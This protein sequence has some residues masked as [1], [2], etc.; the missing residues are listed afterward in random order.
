MEYILTLGVCIILISLLVD[1]VTR[2]EAKQQNVSRTRVDILLAELKELEE[3]QERKS[4]LLLEEA[5]IKSKQEKIK[6]EQSEIELL[7]AFEEGIRVREQERLEILK[8]REEA[9]LAQ[10]A[11]EEARLDE[12][13]AKEE[14]EK[15]ARSVF[16]LVYG[17]TAVDSPSFQVVFCDRSEGLTESLEQSAIVS[18]L[19]LPQVRFDL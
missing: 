6:R 10:K 17:I 14:E 9:R 15:R 7:R 3:E 5:R 12:Q 13:K 4:K 1:W 19:G 8:A 2:G 11:E 16:N 18:R